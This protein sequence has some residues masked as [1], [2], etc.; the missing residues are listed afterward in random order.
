MG[1]CPLHYI[2]RHVYYPAPWYRVFIIESQ[3]GMAVIIILIM[4]FGNNGTLLCSGVKSDMSVFVCTL[5][6]K[7]KIG[8]YPNSCECS[9]GTHILEYIEKSGFVCIGLQNKYLVVSIKSVIVWIQ[10]VEEYVLND[11]NTPFKRYECDITTKII[12][13][14]FHFFSLPCVDSDSLN[15]CK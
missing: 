10:A 13:G 8:T 6:G 2:R 11:R 12:F 15:F 4:V 7:P 1:D 9:E 5:Y 3:I 14:K